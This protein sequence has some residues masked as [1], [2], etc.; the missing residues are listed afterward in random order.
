VTAEAH[1][2]THRE[3]TRAEFW[4]EVDKQAVALESATSATEVLA[5]TAKAPGDPNRANGEGF[6]AGD[7]GD[8]YDALTA[9]G[10]G[11]AWLDASYYFCLVAPNGASRITYVEGDIYRGDQ[12][13]RNA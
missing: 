8:V 11:V 12:R 1:A 3:P 4:A 6:Y 13:R 10:W 9:A 7:G 2:P 5:I